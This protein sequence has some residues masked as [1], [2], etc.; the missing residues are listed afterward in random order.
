MWSGDRVQTIQVHI[1]QLNDSLR[2]SEMPA[3][4]KQWQNKS[5]KD[6]GLVGLKD[7]FCSSLCHENKQGATR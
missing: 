6:E 4:C 2:E 7:E 5:Q 3:S 1:W